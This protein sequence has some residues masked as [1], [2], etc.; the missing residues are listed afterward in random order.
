MVE[1]GVLQLQL[2]LR[3]QLQRGTGV[4]KVVEMVVTANETGAAK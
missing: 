2:R 4:G 3:L 1:V